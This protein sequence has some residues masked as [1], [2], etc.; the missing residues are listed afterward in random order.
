M[1]FNNTLLKQKINEKYG[2]PAA[3]C[4]AAGIADPDTY[5]QE[6]EQFTDMSAEHITRTAEA[7]ELLPEEIGLYFFAPATDP[8]NK[9]NF[10][11]LLKDLT[12]ENQTKVICKYY[13][14]LAA[15]EQCEV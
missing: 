3:L 6:L 9:I 10:A 8:D 2:S 1:K 14:L 13:E 5:E 12:P 4:K 11:E 7:L 15:Q